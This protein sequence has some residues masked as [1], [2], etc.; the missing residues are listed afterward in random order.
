MALSNFPASA[1]EAD[2]ASVRKLLDEFTEELL[3]EYPES[4]TGLGID[5]G[6]RAALKSKLADRSA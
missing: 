6:S 3:S 4:A 1:A 2:N 5:N